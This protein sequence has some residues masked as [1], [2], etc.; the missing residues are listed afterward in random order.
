M[1]PWKWASTCNLPN[2]SGSS[3]HENLAEWRYVSNAGMN[4]LLFLLVSIWTFLVV[5]VR[6]IFKG[7]L[8]PGWTY[9]FEAIAE[10]VRKAV[11][12]GVDVPIEKMR[13]G[14]IPARIH[15]SLWRLVK[16]ER[17]VFAGR[18]T[19]TFTPT[20]WTPA[21]PTLLYFHGGGYITCS[22]ATHRDLISRIAVSGRARTIA[23]DYRKA[24]EYPFPAPIDDCEAAYR[25]LLDAGTPPD[26]IFVGGDSAGGGL[27]L[28]VLQRAKEAGLPLPRAA[29]L[30]SPWVDLECMGE[31]IKDNAAYDYLPPSGLP[32]GVEHYLQGG[33]CR[34]PHVSPVHADL[35]G[36]PPI[37]M[38]TGGAELFLS[39]N[40]RF[41]E[42]VRASGTS[43][44]HRIE[45]G[46]IHVYP[47]FATFVP[48]CLPAIHDIGAFIREHHVSVQEAAA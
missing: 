15:P 33:D 16:H 7:P 13:A 29:V 18:P 10:I 39:E 32:M 2:G 4:T 45:P 26:R 1:R 48:E 38:L 22:P 12:A 40:R 41:A 9:R 27:T 8:H 25:A 43:I 5:F 47:A 17:S 46:M 24:P 11:L 34:H 23:I 35:R 14:M 6:R 30:L 42:L 36:L 28:A 20:G 37:L 44:V 31:S 19:E 21:G 3:A